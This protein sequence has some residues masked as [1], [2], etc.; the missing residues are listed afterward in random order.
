VS[1]AQRYTLP[2][3]RQRGAFWADEFRSQAL[4][5]RNGG[6]ITGAPTFGPRGIGMDGAND[7]VTYDVSVGRWSSTEF[8]CKGWFTPTFALD[9]GAT[10]FLFDGPALGVYSFLKNAANGLQVFLGNTGVGTAV[11]A[12]VAAAW[13]DLAENTIVVTSESG[14]T[15]VWL[16]GVLIIDADATAWAPTPP[17]W[18]V[19]GATN[20]GASKF[21]GT[22]HDL[23]FFNVKLTDQ[24]ALDYCNGAVW[25][26]ERDALF[27]LPM[28]AAND[29]PGVKTTDASGNGRNGTLGAGALAPTK[30][31]TGWG[32]NWDGANDTMLVAHDDVFDFTDAMTLNIWARLDPAQKLN[33]SARYIVGKGDGSFDEPFILAVFY[34]AA[35][36]FYHI[37][38]RVDDGTEDLAIQTAASIDSVFQSWFMVTAIYDAASIRIYVNAELRATTPFAASRTMK[39]NAEDIGIGCAS[40]GARNLNADLAKAAIWDSVLTPMQ[41]CDLYGRDRRSMQ[42]L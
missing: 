6:V 4:V 20:G 34:V 40:N 31:T 13:N 8:S 37:R 38:F 42:R 18:I 14:D 28:L 24:E 26:Y 15:S 25:T 11:Y 12:T 9:D 19:V 30:N 2:A 22:I 27:N 35:D 10:H 17:I 36:G 1:E 3:E 16:N 21:A 23:K 5:E 33:N 29:D 32:Y 41:I 39:T 7:Y